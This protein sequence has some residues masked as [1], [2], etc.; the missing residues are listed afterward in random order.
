MRINAV[1]TYN[2]TRISSSPVYFRSQCSMKI[3]VAE[4]S[5]TPYIFLGYIYPGVRRGGNLVKAVT[6]V[7][8]R[9]QS[10]TA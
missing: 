5:N 4:S 2:H 9:P 10:E 1:P 8:T 6:V 3:S 7:A